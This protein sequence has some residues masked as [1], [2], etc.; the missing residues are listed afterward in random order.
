MPVVNEDLAKFPAESLHSFSFASHSD[1]SIH[2]RH[3]ILKR[4]I[5]FMRDKIEWATD[6]LGIA[7]AKAEISGD[8]EM[9]SIVELLMRARLVPTDDEGPP[10]AV[11]PG[12]LTGPIQRSSENVFD[13]SFRTESPTSLHF[14]ETQAEK[15]SDNSDRAVSPER[16]VNTSQPHSDFVGAFPSSSHSEERPSAPERQAVSHQRAALKRTYT[17]VAP[18][19]LQS[20]LTDALAKP[21]VAKEGSTLSPIAPTP[22]IGGTLATGVTFPNL[23]S[24]AR[25]TPNSQA[26][27]TTEAQAP[28]TISAANDLACLIFGLSKA[29]LRRISILEVFQAEKRKW[30]GNVLEGDSTKSAS[31][32]TS[33][34]RGSPAQ[35]R[36]AL[37]GNGLTARLLSKPPARQRGQQTRSQSDDAIQGG[38]AQTGDRS[39]LD[40]QHVAKSRGVILCG[41]V[42]P[43]VKRNGA[44]G[45]ATLWVQEKRSGLIWVL[46]EIAEDVAMLQVDEIGSVVKVSG[47][48]EAIWGMERVRR[49]MDITRLL[50]GIPRIKGTNT[51]ALDYN[52]IAEL[53]RFTARTANDISIPVTIDQLSG[54]STFR[55]SSFPHIAGMMV[56]SASTLK[57]YSS[58]LKVSEAMFGRNPN[59]LPMSSII[60]DFDKMLD[61]LRE[62]ED[63]QLV[64]GTVIPEHGFRRAR[65]LLA[66]R[67]GNEDAAAVFLKPS[68][69]PA[70]HRDGAQIMID[71]QMRVVKN[72]MLG[73]SLDHRRTNGTIEKE[74]GE[75]T[76]SSEVVYALW[77]TYSR[78]LHAAN[79]GVGRVSPLVSRP[80]TPPQQPPPG[81]LLSDTTDE[82]DADDVR[83]SKS[84][85]KPTVKHQPA[86]RNIPQIPARPNTSPS[87][88]DTGESAKKQ[89]SDFTILEGMGAGAYGQVK[90]A[91]PKSSPSAPKVVIKYVTKRRILVDT[92]T[93]DRRLGTVPLEI[94]VLDYLRR[95]NSDGVSHPNVVEM[96]NFFE[97]DANYYIEMVPHGL[98]G[99]DLFDYIEL[100]VN[101]GED[102][103]RAI[104]RQVASAVEFLHERAKIVHRDIKDENVILDGEG[105]VKLV[106]FG[107]ANYAKNGPFDVFVGTIDYAAP[108]VLAGASYNGREQD[109]WAL[110]ILLYTT[111]YKENPFYNIDEIMDHDLRVPFVVS[112]TSIDLVRKMLER[113]VERRIDIGGVLAHPWLMDQA[114]D[115]V[116]SDE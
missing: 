102:E 43:T 5:D 13:M 84:L 94:H 113:N 10:H 31:T 41:D 33:L 36:P 103:C 98:P 97:D 69:L 110:G 76:T 1:D 87:A 111:L 34:R 2:S 50:P 92:W 45:S 95:L 3:N 70:L 67:E 96:I 108:E 78:M 58:N 72:D 30:L 105:V 115:E 91:R 32:A 68:G 59:G 27:F 109:L 104:F 16:L 35:E 85:T 116:L 89:I 56:L 47:K 53:R 18:L 29:E 80:G 19:S 48:S 61:L 24:H 49:G 99:M 81:D 114:D 37:M 4:S 82:S 52:T 11:S 88:S 14:Q 26:I 51:G 8:P 60:P 42:L 12:P 9:Q 107:S 62:E 15:L 100:R 54:Q 112:D 64:E 71:V 65:A 79:H 40:A 7:K 101:M 77:V 93:R 22:T 86:T 90:L 66:L 74:Q 39:L 75:S 73:E 28:W 44:V 63:V 17:D 25:A 23:A 55:V 106:D 20:R 38:A 6:G 83:A 46:E 57:V 21:Y